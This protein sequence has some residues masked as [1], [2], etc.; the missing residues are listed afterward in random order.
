MNRQFLKFIGVLASVALLVGAGVELS[1]WLEEGKIIRVHGKLLAVVYSAACEGQEESFKGAWDAF[2]LEQAAKSWLSKKLLRQMDVD[3]DAG[4]RVKQIAFKHNN[5]PNT[6][7]NV[8]RDCMTAN[9]G[10]SCTGTLSTYKYHAL[11]TTNTAA[12]ET[13]TACLAEITTAYNPDNQRALGTQTTTGQGNYRTVATNTVDGT[14]A[15]V[16]WCLMNRLS[17]ATVG[18]GNGVTDTI[19]SRIVF[20]VINLAASDSLQTTYDLTIE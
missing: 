3:M 20:S 9:L 11:G 17:A 15:V 5:I 6:A 13:D 8:L 19:W 16:E 7:E 18:Q 10:T 1:P 14:A 2:E 4:C 12:A